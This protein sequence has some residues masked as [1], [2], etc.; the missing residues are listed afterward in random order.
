[1]TSQSVLIN[2][3]GVLRDIERLRVGPPTPAR[4]SWV[5][6]SPTGKIAVWALVNH[7]VVIPPLF[8]GYCHGCLPHS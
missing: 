3:F 7:F 4:N 1:M 2:G 5:R 8:I 6:S